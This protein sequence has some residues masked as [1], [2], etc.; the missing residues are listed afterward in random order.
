ML[1]VHGYNLQETAL[2]P[3]SLVHEDLTITT[4]AEYLF[5]NGLLRFRLPMLFAISGYIFSL[6]DKKPYGQRVKRR[7]QTL[8][9][10][11]FIWSAAGLVLTFLLQAHPATASVVQ[12][13]GIDQLGDNRP[14][15]EIG[16][17][18]VLHRWLFA[19]PSFQL[20]F[21]RSLFV[22]NLAYPLFRWGVTKVPI[23]T[24]AFLFLL[25][26]TMIQLPLVEGQGMF[27]FGLGIW[28]QKRSFPLDRKPSWFSHYLSWLFFAGLCIIKTFMAFEFAE[29]T[30]LLYWTMTLLHVVAV[31]AGVLAVWFSFDAVV[32]WF[33]HKK[34]FVWCT[35]FSF[36]IYGLH[37][38][39]LPYFTAFVLR[40]GNKVAGY[41]L[42]MY[43]L[44][45]SF[46]FLVCLFT[47]ALLRRVVP[48][49]YRLMTGGRGF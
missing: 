23:P 26:I 14:Y 36:F 6:Q 13:A 17:G 33:M 25:W 46:I 40:Y 34:W 37:I 44:V 38:P 28:L 22:Y 29:L 42:L 15:R 48:R 35:A 2:A 32:T 39:L 20:W 43:L 18:G 24:F 31:S 19:P 41:R 7:F 1:F 45:P 49:T 30:P 21:L 5:A 16:W 27:F 4:F 9:I 3:F 12:D 10:P 8:M 47:G 11:Y